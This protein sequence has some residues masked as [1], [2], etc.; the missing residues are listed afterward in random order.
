MEIKKKILIID[1]EPDFIETMKIFLENYGFSVISALEPDEGLI[2]AH[3]NLPDLILLD[4][5]LPKRNGHEVCRQIKEDPSTKHIPVIMLTCEDRTIDKVEAFNLGVA[6]YICKTFS[7]EEILARIRAKLPIP[8]SGIK[9]KRTEKI[10]ELRKI[11]DN[12]N[13]RIFFQPIIDLL[14]QKVIGYEVFSR[15]PKDSIFEDATTLFSFATEE[16]MFLEVELLALSLAIEKAS[17]I[18]ADQYLF[19]NVDPIFLDLPEF[20][21]LSFL[22][23]SALKNSQ[24]CFEI[25]ERTFIKNFAKLSS[26]IS[27][28]KKKEIKFAIDDVGEGYS[29][30][31]AI[32]ELKPTFIKIDID[33]VRNVDKDQTKSTIIQLIV[34]LAKK[35]NILTIAEGIETDQEL[36]TLLS[37]GVNYGQGYLIGKPQQY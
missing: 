15:G 11:I 20:K 36:K 29:S 17:F 4:L 33:I 16:N 10:I 1:D 14:N 31:K 32:V 12:K 9:E 26:T 18:S 25:T 37:L 7:L 8:D 22:K 3:K 30:L 34:E 27:E 2:L 28:F 19:L 6:D 24:I 13:L 35:I 21:G 5:N 23:K